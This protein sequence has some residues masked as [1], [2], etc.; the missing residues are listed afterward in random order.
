MRNAPLLSKRPKVEVE[1]EESDD[2]MLSRVR[3]FINT[4]LLPLLVT[5]GTPPTTMPQN[6][7]TTIFIV[8][9]GILLA[10]FI[11]DLL[12]RFT[13]ISISHKVTAPRFIPP[14]FSHRLDNTAYSLLR[15]YPASS[16]VPLGERTLD[17]KFSN[18]KPT[19]Q[20]PV[21]SS[22][23]PP[24]RYTTYHNR[25]KSPSEPVQG[26]QEIVVE[27]VNVTTHLSGLRRTHGGIGSAIADP[28]Q[29]TL[30]DFF[31]RK[32]KAEEDS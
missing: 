4:E 11:K 22:L 8:S 21:Q 13:T 2:A 27:N 5:D 29:K 6:T 14:T 9:H 28:K 16:S 26:R 31:V 18:P 25:I 32:R 7:P 3:R 30:K 24:S 10:F 12:E 23:Q 17:T 15:L 19:P 20:K 1:M